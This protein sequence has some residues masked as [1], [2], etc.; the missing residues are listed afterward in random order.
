MDQ[1]CASSVNICLIS[2]NGIPNIAI[3]RQTM[4]VAIRGIC[5]LRRRINYFH[6]LPRVLFVLFFIISILLCIAW[7][8]ENRIAVNVPRIKTFFIAWQ[9]A[10]QCGSLLM[11]SLN[12]FPLFQH[13]TKSKM[14]VGMGLAFCTLTRCCW[15]TIHNWLFFHENGRIASINFQRLSSSRCET[16]QREFGRLAETVKDKSVINQT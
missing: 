4:A 8:S 16:M 3:Q 13:K 14:N 15:A 12:K 1:R 6:W 2:R 5:D 10:C 11:V 9:R 7:N